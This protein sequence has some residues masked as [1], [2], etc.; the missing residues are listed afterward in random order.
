MNTALQFLAGCPTK[1]IHLDEQ[2]DV[3]PGQRA[4]GRGQ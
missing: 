3:L 1:M 2:S 4:E